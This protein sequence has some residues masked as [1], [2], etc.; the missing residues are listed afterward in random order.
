MP[1]ED[2]MKLK[3]FPSVL[4]EEK[5][6]FDISE[7]LGGGNFGYIGEVFEEANAAFIVKACNN[8]YQL[9]EALKKALPVVL[10]R[11][12]H[13]TDEIDNIYKEIED[14]IKQAEEL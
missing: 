14:A 12:S 1:R 7:D 8:H 4:V 9:L 3:Y 2:E 10:W 11:E 13:L 6:C 5:P